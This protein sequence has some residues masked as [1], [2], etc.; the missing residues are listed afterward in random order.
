LRTK[1]P[2]D[3]ADLS[4]T[5]HACCFILLRREMASA[6]FAPAPFHIRLIVHIPFER[7]RRHFSFFMLYSREL[8]HMM[9]VC[10][11]ACL[12]LFLILF[13][14]PGRRRSEPP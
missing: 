3:A 4:V 8:Q 10:R 7:E 11:K 2:S 13:D 5:A 12:P 6:L 1:E 9:C 14:E